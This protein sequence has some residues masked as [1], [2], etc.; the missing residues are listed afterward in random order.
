MAQ[1]TLDQML[2]ALDQRKAPGQPSS[3]LDIIKQ[4]IYP[5]PKAPINQPLPR[6]NEQGQ[7]LDPRTLN[8]L[9]MRR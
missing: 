2:N 3:L 6:F 8:D 7:E 1:P 5:Q 4:L 9:L